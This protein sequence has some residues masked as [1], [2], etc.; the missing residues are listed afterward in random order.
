ME[1]TS[2]LWALFT[3]AAAASQ[4]ARNALQ[5][6]LTERLGTL[7]ATHV[8]FLYGLPFG[9]LFLGIV[10]SVAGLDGLVPSRAWLLWTVAGAVFQITATALMLAAMRERT[11]VVTIAYV[12]TE[13]VLIAGFGFLFLGEALGAQSLVA[14]GIATG[15]VLLMSLPAGFAKAPAATGPDGAPAQKTGNPDGAAI[16]GSGALQ[17]LRPAMLGIASGAMFALS[18]VGFRGAIQGLGDA[19]FYVRSTFTLTVALAIQTALLSAWLF[20]RNRQVLIEVFK[21]WRPSLA[22]GFSGALASQMWFLAFSIQTAAAVRTLGLVEILFA[23]AASRKLFAQSTT[24]REGVGIGLMLVG[25]VL[26]VSA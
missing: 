22:A 23:Q 24:R 7:G 11:F 6:S 19:P 5:R 17:Q 10:A 14:I 16:K 2:W 3:I 1:T 12:K 18:A 25:L 15:G 9:I 13:P 20:M 26:L 21:A 4:T 8:R